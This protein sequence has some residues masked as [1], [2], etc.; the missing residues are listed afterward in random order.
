M[1][2][3][4]KQEMEK[5]INSSNSMRSASVKLGLHFNTFSRYAK[6][7]GI[8]KPNRG[9]KG[10]SKPKKE[11]KGKYLLEDILNGKHPEYQTRKLKIRLIKEGIKQNKC[12]ICGIV[13]WNNKDIVC[14]LDHIDGN[15]SNHS[16][17]NLRILC[18]NCHS[19][20]D[21]FRYKKRL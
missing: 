3:I 9:L 12:E 15:S 18:P 10:S 14:E 8:Y 19:Q 5:V 20:T 13:N 11:G 4:T 16:L 7:Y 2:K 1:I 17:D 21:T 6:M